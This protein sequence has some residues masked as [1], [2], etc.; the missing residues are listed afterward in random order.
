VSTFAKF[1]GGSPKA[2]DQ[3]LSNRFAALGL[4]SDTLAN[5]LLAVLVA[6]TVEMTQGGWFRSSK[7]G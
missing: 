7:W 2:E 3:D 5:S 6:C 4:D 1:L